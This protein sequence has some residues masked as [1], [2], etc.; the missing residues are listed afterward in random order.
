[1]IGSMSLANLAKQLNGQLSGADVSFRSL[2]T[3][4]R[5]IHPGDAYLALVGERFDGNDYV[6]EAKQRGAAAAIV[7]KPR[8]ADLPLL[9]VADTHQ[10][11]A[12]IALEN[13][14]R[15][16]ARVIALTGSQGK[17]TVKE[18][19]ASIL[20]KAGPTLYTSANLNNTIGV[21]LTLL[22]LDKSHRFAVI[23]MG[24]NG[25]GEIAFSVN[26]ARPNLALITN[27]S[28]AH[29][30][31]F[32]SL[33]G[34]VEAKGEILDGLQSGG[35]ALLNADDP[36]VGQWIKRAAAHHV[37]LFSYDNKYG[38][39]SYYARKVRIGEQGRVAFELQSPL[40]SQAVSLH[41][42]GKHNVFNAVA[43]ACAAIE[44]GASLEQV[45][46]GLADCET[47]PG[48][49]MPLPGIRGSNI[50]DDSYNASPASFFAAIDVLMTFKGKKILLA[51]DMK[52]LGSNSAEGHF[53]VGN[54]A[55]EAGVD[56]LWAVG[57]A[58]QQTVAGFGG[59]G[60]LFGSQEEL[61]KA[62]RSEADENTVFLIK[63]SRGSRMDVLVEAL[64]E[65]GGE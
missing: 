33:Q 56:E 37:V 43:A 5:T 61:I 28:D 18:M 32:G 65:K 49:L 45:A 29:V 53:A 22:R 36:N 64:R 25:Q 7:S 3:D 19:L 26:A 46:A 39:A 23:E 50:I 60:K 1:M 54:Y 10:A 42:L 30:E 4:T 44:A 6:D 63:G 9:Q 62:G 13:R 24:A 14:L 58:S 21:P 31:G 20:A 35:R 8:K 12:Q 16:E 57:Q 52:E 2:S 41:L 38:Q 47:V 55:R 11:L 17:T 34:I 15:S 51:G 27:A 48:R 59:A 40:G